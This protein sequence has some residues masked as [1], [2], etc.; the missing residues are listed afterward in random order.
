MLV[1]FT[2][3]QLDKNYSFNESGLT[4][5]PSTEYYSRFKKQVSRAKRRCPENLQSFLLN[6]AG[7]L[8]LKSLQY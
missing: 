1:F 7:S 4:R 3:I 8:S 2:A 5:G 6:H